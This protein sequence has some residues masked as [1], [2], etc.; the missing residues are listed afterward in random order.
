LSAALTDQNPKRSTKHLK[1]SRMGNPIDTHDPVA[2][3]KSTGEAVLPHASFSQAMEE[4]D[5]AWRNPR[6]TA[7]ELEPLDV[8]EMLQQ[9]YILSEQAHLS[10]SLLWDADE[11]KAWDPRAYIPHVVREGQ[12]WGRTAL[13][14][15]SQR[16]L[17]AS[18]QRAWNADAFG[19]VLEE[20]YLSPREYKV[21]FLGR[22]E[23]VSEDGKAL[24]RAGGHQPLFHVEHAVGG[25]DSQPLNLWRI[26]HLTPEKD[27]ALAQRQAAAFAEVWRQ[28]IAIYV[29]RELGIKLTRR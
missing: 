17:R 9:H 5:R 14:D 18:Q 4:F 27:D 11:K 1:E 23:L 28:F 2:K 22:A 10:R 21:L 16:F 20:V 7:I 3:A 15:G 13:T 26:V 8:N 19:Q 25:T 24:R 12:S 29:E 6:H